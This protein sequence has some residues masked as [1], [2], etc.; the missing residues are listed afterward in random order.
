MKKIFILVIALVMISTIFTGCGSS[1]GTPT[2]EEIDLEITERY[3][4][5]E[6]VCITPSYGGTHNSLD[7]TT[8]LVTAIDHDNHVHLIDIDDYNIIIIKEGDP[9]IGGQD[10]D[11]A[12]KLFITREDL[13][14]FIN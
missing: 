5:Y 10:G 3:A 4:G 1:D 9:Y 14:N 2:D 6:I 12:K 7:D 8:L 13:V 11:H